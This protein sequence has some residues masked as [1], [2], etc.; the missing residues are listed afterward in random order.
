[1]GA[2]MKL[3]SCLI[4]VCFCLMTF[5]GCNSGDPTQP[6][7]SGSNLSTKARPGNGAIPDE[8]KGFFPLTVG[9]S[10]HYSGTFRTWVV[11]GSVPGLPDTIHNEV[12]RELIGTEVRSG[13]TYI[14]HEERTVQDARPGEIF[15]YKSLY[16][17]DRSGLHFAY[18]CELP[19]ENQLSSFTQ[20]SNAAAN[21]QLPKPKG[22]PSDPAWERAWSTHCKRLELA[23][24]ALSDFQRTAVALASADST[25]C[26]GTL[27]TYPLHPGSNW[28]VYPDDS[29]YIWT[30]EGVEVLTLPAGRFPAY[31]IRISFP[32]LG[33]TDAILVW[34]GRSGRLGHHLHITSEATDGSG[35]HLGVFISDETET[36]QSLHITR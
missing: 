31:R 32:S 23:R 10:W 15:A 36:L 29:D 20:K 12:D 7:A 28:Q 35:N 22:T 18:R 30:V 4:L 27:L 16:R 9:N 33:G 17:Q 34:Y 14:V 25:D 5:G 3:P 21:A 24:S 11:E 2:G 8:Q 13:R 6:L 1:M 19:E 26:E